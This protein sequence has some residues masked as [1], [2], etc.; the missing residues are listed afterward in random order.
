MWKPSSVQQETKWHLW[1]VVGLGEIGANCRAVCN[2]LLSSKI[3]NSVSKSHILM[4]E[5]WNQKSPLE[6]TGEKR[7]LAATILS[8]ILDMHSLYHC[9]CPAMSHIW[10]FSPMETHMNEQPL[11]PRSDIDSGQKTVFFL[12]YC[13]VFYIRVKI[14]VLA[15]INRGALY[16]KLQAK[17]ESNLFQSSLISL[18]SDA[19]DRNP[20]YLFIWWREHRVLLNL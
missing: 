10:F 1:P 11:E 13:Y 16:R 12:S 17:L 3:Q 2:C 8:I 19:M 9:L 5:L 20:E 7:I 4:F 15:R 6:H 14:W 18:W